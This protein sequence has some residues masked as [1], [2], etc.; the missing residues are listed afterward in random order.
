MITSIVFGLRLVLVS[1]NLKKKLLNK[2]IYILHL[3]IFKNFLDL[4]DTTI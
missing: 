3:R 1:T 2:F 4:S